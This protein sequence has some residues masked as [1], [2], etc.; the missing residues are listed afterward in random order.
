VTQ[1]HVKGYQAF[2]DEGEA[3]VYV[4]QAVAS[5]SYVWNTTNLAWEPA[6]GGSGGPTSDVNVTNFP[7]TQVVSGTVAVSNFP[8]P[9]LTDAQLRATPV[10]VSGT[11]AVSNFPSPGLTDAQL[12]ASPVATTTESAF[13]FLEGLA[14]RAVAKLTYTLTGLRVDC[15]GSSVAVTTVATV[16]AVAGVG[17]NSVNGQG[18]QQSQLAYQCGFRRNIT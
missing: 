2:T 15:G 8:S 14:R 3:H 16:T 7:G 1:K 4:P 11:M 10:P 17:S 6:S 9:G 5:H 18:I 13:T 12:R